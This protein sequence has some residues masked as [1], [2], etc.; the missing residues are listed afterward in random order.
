MTRAL[1]SGLSP[2][3][4]LGLLVGCG[5][6]AEAPPA[7]SAAAAPAATSSF[8]PCTLLTAEEVQAAV[9]WAVAETTPY[10]RGDGGRCV[11]KGDATA[12]PL[13][14]VEAGVSVCLSN[15]P[16]TGEEGWGS[17]LSTSTAMADYIRNQYKGTGGET[18]AKLEAAEGL[19]VPAAM[20]ELAGQYTLEMVLG[21]R[22]IASASTWVSAEATR[23]LAEKVLARSK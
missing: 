10:P 13:Q 23:S 16:C 6:R 1:S 5:G 2:V 19:G 4:L 22:R 11:Y 20:Q 9:G 7:D 17:L 8:D 15:F 21:D 12:L 14:S 18:F 3:L